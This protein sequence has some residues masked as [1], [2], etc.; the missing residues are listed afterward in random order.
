M[1]EQAR[2]GFGSRRGTEAGDFQLTIV[3]PTCFYDDTDLDHDGILDECQIECGMMADANCDG[4]VNVFDIDPFVVALTSP[5]QW[6][7]TYACDLLCANDC[8]GDGEVNVFDIDPF[9]LR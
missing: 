7:A 9:V 3:G 8:N 2:T 5:A 4:V 1:A 6:S